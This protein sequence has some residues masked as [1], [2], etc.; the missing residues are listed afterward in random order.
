MKLIFVGPSLPDAKKFADPTVVLRAPARQGDFVQAVHQGAT[1]IGLVDGFF[2][3][4][5]P[6]WHKEILFAL[7][8]GC[9]VFGASSMGAL[10]AVECAAFGMTGIG[11]IYEDYQSGIR[12]DDGDVALQHGPAELGYPALSVPLVNVDAIIERAVSLSLITEQ[13]GRRLTR[14]ARELYF[15]V[16]TWKA[17]GQLAGVD[18]PLLDEVV[19][20][21][22][23]DQKR[24]DALALVMAINALPD[25]RVCTPDWPLYETEAWR[26]IYKTFSNQYFIED[27]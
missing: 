17:I 25:E 18:W 10:R 11:R 19:R 6:V 3:N 9:R 12:F 13:V 16:R 1:A 5:P 26:Q 2:E 15:K 7:K 4:V 27:N 21:V 22:N 24:E 8:Q 20:T 23:F 14:S